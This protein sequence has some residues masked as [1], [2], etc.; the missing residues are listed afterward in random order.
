M[1]RY[2]LIPF[3]HRFFSLFAFVLSLLMFYLW[4]YFFLSSPRFW[5]CFLFVFFFNL[6]CWQMFFYN[7]M[8]FSRRLNFDGDWTSTSDLMARLGWWL[9]DGATRLSCTI[10]QPML[11]LYQLYLLLIKSVNGSS[12]ERKATWAFSIAFYMRVHK[13][14]EQI[15]MSNRFE[16]TVWR[17]KESCMW[18]W[19]LEHEAA[20]KWNTVK[21]WA[22][23]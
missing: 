16:V 5:V 15:R 23:G 19:G 11:H 10:I 18:L 7:D 3:L 4:L 20:R 2:R 14:R 22:G 1:R 13:M 8:D 12:N 17:K 6:F 21:S 9:F